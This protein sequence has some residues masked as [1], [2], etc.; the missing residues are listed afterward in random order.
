MNI[1]STINEIQASAPKG[2]TITTDPNALPSLLGSAEL[3][4]PLRR[5]PDGRLELILLAQ[6]T[7]NNTDVIL[8][9]PDA[10]GVN[11]ETQIGLSRANR[12]MQAG[13]TSMA[14]G[15][16]AGKCTLC[17]TDKPAAGGP[18]AFSVDNGR[19]FGPLIHKVVV[20]R[21]HIETLNDEALGDAVRDSTEQF[22][23]IAFQGRKAMGESLDGLTIGMNLGEYAR[24]GASQL[25]FHYQVTGL[26]K[27]NY[28]AGD[29]LG[30]ICRAYQ[31]KSGA[32]YLEDY[33]RAL[34]DANLVVARN[35]SAIAYAPV[36][37]RFKGEVQIMLCKCQVGN[38]LN[39]TEG[40]RKA[41]ADLQCKT[42]Q[43][44]HRLGCQALNQVWYTTR[45]SAKDD[46]GQRLIISLCP[47]TSIFAFYE[48][49]GNNVIDVLPWKSAQTLR[50]AADLHLSL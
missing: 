42:M 23:E 4:T 25:H 40:D 27:G 24:S 12:I 32:D 41:L 34:T 19:P 22:Y 15:S 43:R 20:S 10:L 28:N 8:S 6:P 3:R 29:R 14:A 16:T 45:F 44:F 47:R 17:P 7:A 48:L 33:E 21:K 35:E 11:G 39:T 31:E 2:I 46:I 38:I 50:A 1:Q 13:Q 9:V 26:G 5:H 49:S 36:S 37:P 30:A 18:A